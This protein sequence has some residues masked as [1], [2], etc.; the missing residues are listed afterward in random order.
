MRAY[1]ASPNAGMKLPPW[2]VSY[3]P[4]CG[5][6]ARRHSAP[7]NALTIAVRVCCRSSP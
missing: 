1:S 6:L 3:T 7:L 4:G 2:P 5:W